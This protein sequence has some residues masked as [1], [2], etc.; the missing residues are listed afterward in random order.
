VIRASDPLSSI[1]EDFLAG[2]IAL[3]LSMPLL[4]GGGGE[5]KKTSSAIVV[6]LFAVSV[7]SK[8]NSPSLLAFPS[9]ASRKKTGPCHDTR[10]PSLWPLMR[11]VSCILDFSMVSKEPWFTFSPNR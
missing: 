6:Q 5:I 2:S 9:L 7:I 4:R 11:R 10:T 3:S 8:R 1:A